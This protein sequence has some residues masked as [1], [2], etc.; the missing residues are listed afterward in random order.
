MTSPA[1]TGRRDGGEWVRHHTSGPAETM[2]RIAGSS[3]PCAA[4]TAFRWA[5]I[6]SSVRPG[7][8]NSGSDAKA[9][10]TI[11]AARRTDSCSASDLTRRTRSTIQSPGTTRAP[12]SARAAAISSTSGAPGELR[13]AL[14]A[15][16]GIAPPRVSRPR[17]RRRPPSSS[18]RRRRRRRAPPA[19]PAC[20]AGR[21]RRRRAAR[22]RPR[23]APRPV[24]AAGTRS[25]RT[26]SGSRGSAGSGR[27]ARPRRGG[28]SPP[29]PGG[30]GRGTRR[31]RTGAPYRGGCHDRV[32]SG[33]TDLRSRTNV[34]ARPGHRAREGHDL[35]RVAF[36]DA[37][38]RLPG[39]R[40][41]VSSGARART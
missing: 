17:R 40:A 10:S 7:R 25:T 14:D 27:A 16:R 3:P 32:A 13:P 39:S 33:H 41:A 18:R 9:A 26:R 15:D 11:S 30:P 21:S 31:R 2:V 1:S 28:P 23:E 6:S 4:M 20:G 35:P 19:R 38:G 24:R 29:G 8:T 37:D 36:V 34:D 12:P 22:L 5:A